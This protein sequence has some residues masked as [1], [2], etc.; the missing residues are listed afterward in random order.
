MNRRR[1]HSRRQVRPEQPRKLDQP[2]ALAAYAQASPDWHEWMVRSVSLRTALEMVDAGEAEAV[3]RKTDN[4]LVT[5]YRET[6]PTR[7]SKSSPATLTFATM[8]AVAKRRDERLRP[9]EMA[10]VAKF[11]VWPFIGDTRAVAVRP[12]VT[13]R[14]LRQAQAVSDRACGVMAV[15]KTSSRGEVRAEYYEEPQAA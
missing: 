1:R 7:A 10:H 8:L 9:D 12:R 11:L 2:V 6:K 14:E 5:I 4:G 15:R 3:T 13:E